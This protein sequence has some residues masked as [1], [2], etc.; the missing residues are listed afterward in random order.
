VPK[1]SVYYSS[2]LVTKLMRSNRVFVLRMGT[3]NKRWDSFRKRFI[4]E[5]IAS[6]VWPKLPRASELGKRVRE[7]KSIPWPKPERRKPEPGL[8]DFSP[9]IGQSFLK[10]RCLTYFDREPDAGHTKECCGPDYLSTPIFANEHKIS[11]A[12][13][14]IR[15]GIY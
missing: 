2:F 3:R 9:Y 6:A 14:C 4:W 10:G 13:I 7:K 5:R 11:C 1:P 12:K 8:S 15:I